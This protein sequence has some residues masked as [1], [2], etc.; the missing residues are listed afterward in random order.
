MPDW[1]Y[2]TLFRPALFALPAP[3]ARD[4]AFGLMGGW[5]RCP[6]AGA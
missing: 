6:S 4:L 5:R 1:S 2:Q 3:L